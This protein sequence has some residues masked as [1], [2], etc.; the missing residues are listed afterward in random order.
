MQPYPS[1]NLIHPTPVLSFTHNPPN[2]QLSTQLPAR[3]F[4]LSVLHNLYTMS[5]NN[6]LAGFFATVLD[7]VMDP[8]IKVLISVSNIA[9][10]RATAARIEDE[11]SLESVEANVNQVSYFTTLF[12]PLSTRTDIDTCPLSQMTAS[13]PIAAAAAAAAVVPATIYSPG[14]Q[15]YS[16]RASLNRT[17]THYASAHP[18]EFAQ[19]ARKQLQSIDDALRSCSSSPEP[20]KNVEI[21]ADVA[22]DAAAAVAASAPTKT[23]LKPEA[24][25]IPRFA[26]PCSIPVSYTLATADEEQLPPAVGTTW[27]DQVISFVAQ[28]VK[29]HRYGAPQRHAGYGGFAVMYILLVSAQLRAALEAGFTVELASELLEASKIWITYDEKDEAEVVGECEC[30]DVV[31]VE[32]AAS[33]V[34]GSPNGSVVTLVD[35]DSDSEECANFFSIKMEKASVVRSVSKGMSYA[36][37]LKT[38][39]GSPVLA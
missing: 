18:V 26:R 8:V 10:V 35:S 22:G 4:Q 36:S 11:E 12:L 32:E 2:P 39:P 23:C 5:L 34:P 24:T 30:E 6:Y 33:A 9:G 3:S 19:L 25:V 29:E 20:V 31:V 21:A 16:Y 1:P 28:D 15:M 38:P 7:S 17:S 27:R 37:V 14:F 13:A